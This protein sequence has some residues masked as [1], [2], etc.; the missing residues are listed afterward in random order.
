[1]VHALSE[2]HAPTAQ[3]AGVFP[4]CSFDMCVSGQH[5]TVHTPDLHDQT[6]CAVQL[7]SGHASGGLRSN[8]KQGLLQ[9]WLRA[10]RPVPY[11]TRPLTQATRPV[12]QSINVLSAV[13]AGPLGQERPATGGRRGFESGILCYGGS[14][15]ALAAA[16]N[17]AL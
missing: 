6:V 3:L 13:P 12:P 10:V 8:P 2:A 11:L 15:R 7:P 9:T 14:Q 5:V 17:G 1:M 16:R 4:S